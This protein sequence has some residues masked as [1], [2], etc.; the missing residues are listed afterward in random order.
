MQDR[1]RESKRKARVSKREQ[2]KG[3]TRTREG[4]RERVCAQERKSKYIGKV[5]TF[6]A[7]LHFVDH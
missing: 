6:L 4:T 2:I 3:T 5:F 7:N 1:E